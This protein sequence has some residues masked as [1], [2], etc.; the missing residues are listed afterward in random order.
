MSSGWEV[1]TGKEKKSMSERGKMSEGWEEV[2]TGEQ[3]S[4]CKSAR[5]GIEIGKR[6]E[7]KMRG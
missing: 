5:G 6:R 1:E 3:K 4:G 2:E 7:K